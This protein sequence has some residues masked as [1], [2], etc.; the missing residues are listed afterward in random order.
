MAWLLPAYVAIGAWRLGWV[1]GDAGVRADL[2]TWTGLQLFQYAVVALL[3]WPLTLGGQD[4][5]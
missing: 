3:W 4:G 2:A 5:E 1:L